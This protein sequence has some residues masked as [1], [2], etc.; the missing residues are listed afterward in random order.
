MRF[1]R[2]DLN[3]LVALD[4]L[5]TDCSITKAADRLNLSPS[6]TSNA[7][8]RLREYFDDDLLVQVGRRMEPTP[9]ALGLHEAVRDVLVRVDSAIA[10][11]PAFEPAKSDR[12]FRIFVSDYTQMVFVPHLMALAHAERCSARFEFLPQVSHPQRSLERGEAD[13]LIIPRGFVSPDHPEEKLYL[14]D[15]TC[16][17][18]RHGALARGEFNL[19]RYVAARHV[20]MRPP[21]SF[22][23]SFE[24]SFVKRHGIERQVAVT[25]YGFASLAPLVV[26][27]DFVA[28]VHK[29]LALKLL[30]SLPIALRAPPLPLP[31][32]EQGLQWHKYRTQDPGLA[33]LRQLLHRAAAAMDAAMDTVPH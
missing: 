5:L 8:A 4:A 33:W 29:R 2:L 18:W 3:L 21:G 20:V 32:M 31:A 19:E 7:L 14:D 23:D 28:T 25:S 27:T 6:A 22:G 16:V 12:V 17:V 24:A 10:I 9:R 11:P 15:F 13:L 26:G 30:P 1:N